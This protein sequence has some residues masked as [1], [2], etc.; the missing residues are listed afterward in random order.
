MNPDLTIVL[1]RLP[2]GE[3]LGSPA[4]SRWEPSGIGLADALLFD[5]LGVVGRACQTLLLTPR[6]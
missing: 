2:V 4:V 3:W 5:E 6:S 1:H